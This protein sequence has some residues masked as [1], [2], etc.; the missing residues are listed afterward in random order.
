[1]ALLSSL[2]SREGSPERLIIL[3]GATEL[4][5]GKI[6]KRNRADWPQC[7]FSLSPQPALEAPLC[8]L[9]NCYRGWGAAPLQFYLF[10]L[11]NLRVLI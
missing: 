8:L 10:S 3:P 9:R 6:M 4:I 11:L 2:S 7:G 5:C 1:M